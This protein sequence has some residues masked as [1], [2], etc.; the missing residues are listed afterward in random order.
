MKNW[1]FVG[2]NIIFCIFNC[3]IFQVPTFLVCSNAKQMSHTFDQMISLIDSMQFLDFSSVVLDHLCLH[4]EDV[5]KKNNKMDPVL[6]EYKC[7][8]LSPANL[9]QQD[10]N[11]F[12][13]DPN[14]INTVYNF[15]VR[16]DVDLC[17]IISNCFKIFS[18]IGIEKYEVWLQPNW[19]P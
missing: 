6:P 19:V 8:I 17:F 15:Q 4:I 16:K 10:F 9:W 12:Q 2:E 14:L 18:S 13:Q 11:K 5:K 1:D 3:V 7:L